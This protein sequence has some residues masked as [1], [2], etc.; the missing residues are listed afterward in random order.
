MD[1]YLKFALDLVERLAF[2]IAC[3][4][5]KQRLPKGMKTKKS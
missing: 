4:V 1:F 2:K 3:H 5:G